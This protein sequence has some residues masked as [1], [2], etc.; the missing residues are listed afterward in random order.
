[1]ENYL[2]PPSDWQNQ[3]PATYLRLRQGSPCSLESLCCFVAVQ[4][5][6]FVRNL[7]VEPCTAG[8]ACV[9]IV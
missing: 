5:F 9:V 1:M 6:P 3:A 7:H 4:L 8:C 2:A